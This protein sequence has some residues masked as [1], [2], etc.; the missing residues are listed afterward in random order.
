MGSV[1]SRCKH[2]KRGKIVIVIHDDYIQKVNTLPGVIDRPY[3]RCQR[4]LLSKQSMQRPSTSSLY[5]TAFEKPLGVE[6][7]I[8]SYISICL[9]LEL[10][11]S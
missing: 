8:S 10:T 6:G 4:Y 2:K 7:N 11:A 3:H 1:S 5:S 9:W